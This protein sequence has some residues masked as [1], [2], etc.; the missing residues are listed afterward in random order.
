MKAGEKFLRWHA[1]VPRRCWRK[2]DAHKAEQIKAR[3]EKTAKSY[4]YPGDV[5]AEREPDGHCP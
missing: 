5:Q 2:L 3:F 4:P 1:K